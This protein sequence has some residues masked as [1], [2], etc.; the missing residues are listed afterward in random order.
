M[1]VMK[2]DRYLTERKTSEGLTE[3]QFAVLAGLSQSQVNRLRRGRVKPSYEAIEGIIK[4]TG[5]KV[6]ANDFFPSK[7]TE[8][9]K[10]TG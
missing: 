5:G 2:L 9:L 4:A 3:E 8:S 7:G 6:T 1:G 10:A